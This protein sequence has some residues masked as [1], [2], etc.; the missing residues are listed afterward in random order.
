LRASLGAGYRAPDFKELYMEFLN[1][2]PGV[3]YAVRGNADLTPET[4]TNV[5]GSVEWSGARVYLRAQAYHNRFTDFIETRAEGDSAGVTLYTYGNIEDGRTRGLE[6]EAGATW[7]GLRGE[8]GYAWLD[9]E[10]A[11]TGE[12]L[13]GRPAHS[14]RLSLAYA[15]PF[16]LRAGAAG[17]Y[18]G[19]TPL[20]RMDGGGVLDRDGFLR[21]DLRFAQALPG[22]LELAA[23]VDNVL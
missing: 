15:L 5:T 12:P 22:G 23:G 11:D 17:V 10:R 16:G 13:L 8:A 3:A 4:S 6:L 18:T 19:R 21:V 1:I 9:A 14:G 20:Q 7:G 2:A